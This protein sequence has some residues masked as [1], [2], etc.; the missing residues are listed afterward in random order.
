MFFVVGASRSGTTMTGRIL[1]LNPQVFMLNELHFFEQRWQEADRGRRLGRSEARALLVGLFS[2]QRDGYF[3]QHQ[4]E[5]YGPEAD[6]LLTRH[7]LADG[8]HEKH[9]MLSIFAGHEAA[10]HGKV[11]WCEQ[12]P[13]NVYYIES[14]RSVFPEARFLQVIRDP[15][16][17]LLS[18][19][20]RWKRRRLTDPSKW[21]RREMIR[22]WLN[23][24]PITILKLW[25]GANRR[26]AQYSGQP[27]F[28]AFRYEDLLTRP[29]PTLRRICEFLQIEF[30]PEMLNV[31]HVGSSLKADRPAERGLNA[32]KV[33]GWRQGGL[34]ASEIY[35]CERM[36]GPL[37]REFGY[38][39]SGVAPNVAVLGQYAT[40][41]IKLGL[42][43]P[44]SLNRVGSL[45]DAIRRRF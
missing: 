8:T 39:L 21:P 7:G 26:V 17:V 4:N 25:Q 38:E 28:H 34:S 31:P 24:H 5:Q 41:P 12:T 6:D 36:A 16:D 19:K 23:Y 20:N 22:Q 18:Q 45:S 3:F 29:E 42:A 10:L 9:E 15:R 33:D 13:R 11:R 35:L 14:I 2:T 27:F 32:A 44:F 30:T 1:G 37:M 43:L 40:F